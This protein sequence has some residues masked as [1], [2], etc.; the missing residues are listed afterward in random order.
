MGT[1]I[2]NPNNIV[3]KTC[4]RGDM[5]FPD[6]AGY[7]EDALRQDGAPLLCRYCRDSKHPAV[8]I[9]LKENLKQ[10]FDKKLEQWR[11]ENNSPLDGALL[12][13]G[14]A[15]ASAGLM[16]ETDTLWDVIYGQITFMAEQRQVLPEVLI[17]QLFQARSA[18]AFMLALQI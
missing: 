1:T 12:D 11:Q 6:S 18:D 15:V 7:Y 13:W 17:D 2:I 5:L 9:K 16:K 8:I 10:L 3:C 4:K 14:G